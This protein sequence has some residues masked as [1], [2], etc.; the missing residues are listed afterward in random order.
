MVKVLSP[1][2]GSF[3]SRNDLFT[4]NSSQV[5]GQAEEDDSELDKAAD[6]GENGE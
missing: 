6:E 5:F 2:V 1:A 4:K 3:L